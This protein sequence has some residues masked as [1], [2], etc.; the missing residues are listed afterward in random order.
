MHTPPLSPLPPGALAAA[1]AHRV[2]VTA[3]M[4]VPLVLVTVSLM[5]A[6]VVLP[7]LP[8]GTRRAQAL[9][10]RLTAW[11]RTILTGSNSAPSPPT[12]PASRQRRVVSRVRR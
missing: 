10:G 7:L 3:L 2:L 4:A 12:L 6:L 9:L 5:P 1:G 8:D 11:T